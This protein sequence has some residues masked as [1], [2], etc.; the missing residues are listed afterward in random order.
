MLL[1]DK[2][3]FAVRIEVSEIEP[4]IQG[5][6]ALWLKGVQIG[7]FADQEYLW[8]FFISIQRIANDSGK[9]WLDELEGLSCIEAFGQISPFFDNPEAFYDLTDKESSALVKYDR[10]L[11]HFGENFDDWDIK[12]IVRNE[13]CRFLWVSLIADKNEGGSNAQNANCCDVPL[14]L[15]RDVFSQML[16]AV[17]Y[18]FNYL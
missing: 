6:T 7:D 1:G 12:V 17:S 9:L 13:T 18:K 15:V 11:F 14:S 4:D 10:F 2:S 16:E 5:R 8:P 3:I